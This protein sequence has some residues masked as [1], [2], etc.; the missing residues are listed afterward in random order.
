MKATKVP[1]KVE[2]SITVGYSEVGMDGAV[3][4]YL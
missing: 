3:Q 2:P 1:Y 4:S